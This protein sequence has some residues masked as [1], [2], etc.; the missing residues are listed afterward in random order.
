MS[1]LQYFQVGVALFFVISGYCI[2]AA[3][4]NTV[5]NHTSWRTFAWR[6]ARRIYPPY[7]IAL[8]GT[9]LLIAALSLL[10]PSLLMVPPRDLTPLPGLHALSNGQ[11]LG[12][13]TLLEGVRGAF[14]GHENWV[15]PQAWSLGFE[16][17]FY[18]I[19]GLL[20]F[21]L[22]QRWQVGAAMVS[23]LTAGTAVMV[24]PAATGGLFLDGRWLLFALGLAVNLHL[25]QPPGVRRMA[26]PI[27]LVVTEAVLVAFARALPWT[28]LIQY[29]AGTFFAASL[30]ALHRFD[31]SVATSGV[32]APLRWCGTRC[33]S[34]YLVHYPVCIV[35]G[36]LAASRGLTTSP[37]ILGLTLPA[38]LGTTIMLTGLFFQWCERPFLNAT[39]GKV[40]PWSVDR[41]KSA[42]RAAA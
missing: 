12:N 20:I 36:S 39:A 37:Q 30:V 26:L 16:E 5:R 27:T 38:A 3:A 6:R 22:G 1:L 9:A 33:Y 28:T 32:L 41:D 25:R 23:L 40:A 18:A 31:T 2:A 7:L 15:M 21:L 4:D 19:V 29:L 24:G 11:W 14:R 35:I 13:A 17:Q 10:R 34:M 42:A 8:A